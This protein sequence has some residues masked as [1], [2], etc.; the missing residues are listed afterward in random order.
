MR[1]QISAPLCL[2]DGRWLA[3][4]V[5]RGDP[6]TLTLWQTNDE[7][8]T[9]P[10]GDRLVVYTH[11]ERADVTR[12][13]ERIDFN[14]YW[15]DMGKWSFGHPALSQHGDKEVLCAFYAGTPQCMS[16]HWARVS[17]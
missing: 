14:Q 8:R 16:I 1:G 4:V 5:D 9:W 15:E 11:D 3:F 2:P 17:L 10:T 12:G 7:G 6:C 13:G